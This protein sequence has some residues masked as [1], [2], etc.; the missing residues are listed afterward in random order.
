MKTRKLG[1]LAVSSLGL[2]CMSMSQS[3]GERN[4]DESIATLERAIELG[5]TFW[6]TADAYGEGHNESLIG[7]VLAKHRDRVIIAT[8]C[9]IVKNDYGQAG[10]V[11]G[12][13]EYIRQACDASLRRLGIATIDLYYL[14]RVDPNVPIEESAGAMAELVR[15]GKIRFVGLSEVAA[16]TLRRAHK[17]HPITAVQSEYSLWFREPEAQI[18]PA[19][20]ELGV[21]FVPF[22]PLGRAILTGNISA[23]AK[24][25]PQDFRSRLPRFQA[26]N[27]GRNVEL[28]ERFQAI[29][30]EKGCT[31]SQLALAWLLAK[32]TDI[33]PIPGTKRRKY[34]QENTAAAAINLT[35]DEVR[36]IEAAIPAEAVAGARYPEDMMK[37]VDR[38]H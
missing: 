29:A 23:A 20:R 28:V 9:G 25:P 10:G 33:V 2:G 3:Y 34:L 14:H 11:N 21:G 1:T 16:D 4:D 30:R 31:A 5:V 8:K 38:A 12:R 24:F 37:R 22:S 26:E 36:K 18:L 13:P 7:K 15:R 19:C 27:L 35:T 6:D 17:V 32:G